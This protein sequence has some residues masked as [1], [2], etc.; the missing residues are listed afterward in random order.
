MYGG[1][2]LFWNCQAQNANGISQV[3]T[4][5]SHVDLSSVASTL[6]APSIGTPIFSG[7]DEQSAAMFS[8]IS[9]FNFQS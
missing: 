4:M 1:Q 6:G 8:G 3:P 2:L 5:P 7:I 9:T